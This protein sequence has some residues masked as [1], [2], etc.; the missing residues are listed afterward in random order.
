M[1][2]DSW[3]EMMAKLPT[4]NEMELAVAINTEASTYRRAAVIKR[5][6][7]RYAKLRNQRERDAIIAGELLL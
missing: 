4:L 5:L 7:Q 3:K 2:F 6:H 1:T